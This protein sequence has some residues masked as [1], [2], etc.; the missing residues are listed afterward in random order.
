MKEEG[1]DVRVFM[2]TYNLE[3]LN[4]P[5]SKEFMCKLDNTEYKLLEPFEKLQIDDQNDID[6]ILNFQQY[7]KHGDPWVDNFKSLD[8]LLR[9]LYSLEQVTKMWDETF[10]FVIYCRPDVKFTKRL[11]TQWIK[12]LSDNQIITPS[13]DSFGFMNDRFAIGKPSVMKIYGN[14]RNLAYEYSQRN[15][16]HSETFLKYVIDR[17]EIKSTTIDFKF[18]RVRANGNVQ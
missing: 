6:K 11:D 4:N 17:H 14:R 9:Q 15:K 13:F 1:W 12:D 5:R 7:R 18:M 3:Y 10:D 2:H 8:N 16:L